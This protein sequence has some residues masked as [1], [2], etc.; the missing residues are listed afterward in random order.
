MNIQDY[1]YSEKPHINAWLEKH[2]YSALGHPLILLPP[3]INYYM[4][5]TYIMI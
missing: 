4:A 5:R 2:T 1:V 3:S